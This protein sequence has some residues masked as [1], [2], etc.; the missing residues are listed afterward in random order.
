MADIITDIGNFFGGV[1]QWA[2]D[3]TGVNDALKTMRLLAYGMIAIAIVM[4]VTR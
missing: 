4:V 2:G 3:V 1:G